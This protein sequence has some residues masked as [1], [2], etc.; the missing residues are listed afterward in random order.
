MA[1]IELDGTVNTRDVGGLPLADGAGKVRDGVLLRSDNLQDLS[2]ADVRR[3][4]DDLHVRRVVDLRTGVELRG[5]GPGRL[6]GVPGVRVDHLS[7]FPEVG[8][9]TDAAATEELEDDGPDILPWARKEGEKRHQE[10]E[11]EIRDWSPNP[12]ARV[13]LRYLVQRPDSI[14]AALRDIAQ[15]AEDHG[16]T[17]VH[18]AAGK[19]RTGTVVALALDLVGVDRDAIEAD[20][21]ATVPNAAAIL[22]RLLGSPTYHDDV[23]GTTVEDHAPRV[24][25]MPAVLQ[26]IDE[27]FG[28][29]AAFLASA[30]W[31][32]ADTAELRRA[33]IG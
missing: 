24:G 12:V 7:L 2:D 11:D 9:T 27:H 31:T 33:L 25:T 19:D 10:P 6:D 1:D 20:Y 30:G 22:D 15:G 26:G 21:L 5:T 14:V 28:G 13:Y 23:A 8:E 3:L 17:I 32:D 29:T 16:A 4:V 18:C